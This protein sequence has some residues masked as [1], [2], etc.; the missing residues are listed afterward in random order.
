MPYPS[1]SKD[2]CAVLRIIT[3]DDPTNQPV[4]YLTNFIKQR[5]S[6]QAGSGFASPKF[7]TFLEYEA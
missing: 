1:V 7:A 4:G 6:L 5:H 3:F 2:C